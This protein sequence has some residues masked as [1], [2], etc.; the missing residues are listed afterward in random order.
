MT[1]FKRNRPHL[2]TR[3][4]HAGQQPCPLT[5]AVIPAVYTSTTYVQDGIG[6]NRGYNYS[7][8][9]NPTRDTLESCLA[10]LE[11]AERAFAFPSGLSAAATMLETLPAG[12]RILAHRDLYGGI[13]RLLADVRPATAGHEVRFVDFADAAALQAAATDDI[14]MLWFETPSNPLLRVVDLTL[15]ASIGR[16]ID[17]VTVCDS[18]F[19]SPVGQLPLNH[20]LDAVMHSATKFLSGH[21]DMLGGV[22][23]ISPYAKNELSE[24][25]GYLQNALGAVMCP[26]DCALL[27]RSLKTLAVRVERQAD[28][29]CFLAEHLAHNAEELGI[30]EVIYPGL[31]AHP[32]NL[33]ASGQMHN[34]GAMISIRVRGGEVRAERMMTSTG[35]FR[36]AVSLGGVE[37]LV[38]HPA[39][40]THATVPLEHRAGTG[41]EA[42]LLRL[43]VG[44]ENRHDLLADLI[45]ALRGSS[46]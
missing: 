6:R 18:T 38:Q 16:R 15:V 22:L 5:G 23:A 20:G 14:D 33:V 12:S 42:N 43:S 10:D 19:A 21:S 37:S 36:F 31:A 1:E 44:I 35:F 46:S 27:L 11:N 26:T 32:Q 17:A 8:V 7:R 2:E 41:I 13:Y 28:N 9:R 30:E 34:F 40:L 3:V 29:A 25:I 39:S 45:Q 24:R 4:I